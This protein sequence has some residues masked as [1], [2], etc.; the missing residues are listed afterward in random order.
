MQTWREV[1]N[2]AC[3]KFRKSEISLHTGLW[4]PSRK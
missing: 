3:Q 1:R 4:I 2:F